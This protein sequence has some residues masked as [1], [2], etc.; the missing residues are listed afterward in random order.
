MNTELILSSLDCERLET[1]LDSTPKNLIQNLSG[2][3][4]KLA[5]ATYVKPCEMPADRVSM[6]SI[7][8]FSLSPSGKHFNLTLVYP[9]EANDIQSTLSVFSP[10]GTALLG[11]RLGETLSTAPDGDEAHTITLHQIHYQPERD[12]HLHR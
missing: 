10:I 4:Y 6:N 5:N 9:R 11:A 2:L 3:Q 7:V 1:L 8:E 12:G